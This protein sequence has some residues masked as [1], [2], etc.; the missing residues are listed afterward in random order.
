MGLYLGESIENCL[1]RIFCTFFLVIVSDFDS[2]G[3]T[4]PYP[5][6]RQ[7]IYVGNICKKIS[8]NVGIG[9]RGE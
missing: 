7:Y 3:E 1:R 8:T 5:Y 4:S 2:M 6:I 9:G